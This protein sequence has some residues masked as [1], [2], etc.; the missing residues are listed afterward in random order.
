MKPG[1]WILLA[2][3]IIVFL[4]GLLIL[5]YTFETRTLRKTSQENAQALERQLRFTQI[6]HKIAAKS[7]L[8]AS[9]TQYLAVVEDRN[10]IWMSKGQMTSQDTSDLHRQIDTLE[11]E[12][13]ALLKDA[14]V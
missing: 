12:S 11:A 7:A 4:T 10:N 3:T 9:Y 14:E 13:N 5:W 6:G 8:L 1:D 2:Q